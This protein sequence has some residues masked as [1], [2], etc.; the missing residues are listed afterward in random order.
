VSAPDLAARLEE[1]TAGREGRE[2]VEAV[3][4]LADGLGE[5]ERAELGRLLLARVGEQGSFDYGL[6]RRI[7]EPYLQLFRPRPI[8]PGR[9]PP[10]PR[11]GRRGRG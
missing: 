8:E 3:R 2:L 10:R 6:I 11:R 1:A 4:R 5:E 7:E 9:E